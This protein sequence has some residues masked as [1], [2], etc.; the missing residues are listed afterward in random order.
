MSRVPKCPNPSSSRSGFTDFQSITFYN[1]SFSN[2]GQACGDLL[3]TSMDLDGVLRFPAEGGW[4]K[5]S[6]CLVNIWCISNMIW[7]WLCSYYTSY[8]DLKVDFRPC[9]FETFKGVPS[10]AIPICSGWLG[11]ALAARCQIS[12]HHVVTHISQMHAQQNIDNIIS[13]PTNKVQIHI[14]YIYIILYNQ[15]YIYIYLSICTSTTITPQDI[16]GFL[17]LP[18]MEALQTGTEVWKSVRGLR[19]WHGDFEHFGLADLSDQGLWWEGATLR[20]GRYIGIPSG[21]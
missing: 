6:S 9:Y 7:I 15:L 10:Q 20:Q 5:T 21:K 1:A 11:C 13:S 17:G 14:Q 3:A 12:L 18:L 16:P 19:R 2:P 8:L 4:W